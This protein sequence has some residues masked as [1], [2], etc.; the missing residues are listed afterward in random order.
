[1]FKS[2]KISI[3]VVSLFLLVTFTLGYVSCTQMYPSGKWRYKITVN[4]ETPEGL[5][6]GAAVREVTFKSGPKILPDVA[7]STS[8]VTGEAVVID[9]GHGKYLFALMDVDGSYQI[10]HDIFPYEAS[11]PRNYIEYYQS[12]TGQKKALSPSQYPLLVTFADIKDPKTVKKV[13]SNDLSKA[14][15]Q[16]IVLKDMTLEMTDENLTFKIEGWLTWLLNLK[17]NIDG[18]FVTTSRDLSN[19]LHVGNFKRGE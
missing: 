13:S 12:L 18:T 7:G 11:S 9:L 19:T 6:S 16:G 8:K 5:K 14:F 1:L 3:A 10:V 17:S 15:G 4:V 2:G